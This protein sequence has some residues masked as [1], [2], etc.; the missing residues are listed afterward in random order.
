MQQHQAGLGWR[1]A[2][3]QQ[4][5]SQ[6]SARKWNYE[7]GKEGHQRQRLRGG[8]GRQLSACSLLSVR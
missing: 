7:K 5:G 3:E 4:P 1:G 2:Q 6:A 8:G